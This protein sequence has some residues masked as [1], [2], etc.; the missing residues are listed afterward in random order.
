VRTRP[1]ANCGL[2]HKLLRATVRIKL[3]NTKHAK[4]GWKL[5]TENIPEEYKSEIKQKLATKNLQGGNSEETWIAFERPFQGGGKQNHP[6]KGKEKRNLLDVP[7]HAE[8]SGEQTA[9]ENEM[10]WVEVR[11]LNGQIQRRI[12]TD[13]EIYLKKKCQ[14]LEEHNKKG[15]KREHHQQIREI[16]GKPKI[17]AGMIQNRAGIEYIEKDK[18]IR[19]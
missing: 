6:E 19:R 16:T 4:K 8:G 15:R 17:N 5:D 10:K 13:K 2:D 11:K 3:K 14:V 12:R 1:E 18:I 9:N 7:R